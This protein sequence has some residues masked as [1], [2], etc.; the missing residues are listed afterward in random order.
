MNNSSNSIQ[1]FHPQ[2]SLSGYAP[3]F[4]EWNHFR[5]ESHFAICLFSTV[6]SFENHRWTQLQYCSSENV[7]KRLMCYSANICNKSSSS[8]SNKIQVK[9][10]TTNIPQSTEFICRWTGMTLIFGTSSSTCSILFYKIIYSTVIVI[11]NF[12]VFTIICADGNLMSP[13]VMWNLY[14]LLIF[15]HREFFFNNRASRATVR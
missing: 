2:R 15:H 8:S 11:I 6:S 3:T 7:G 12:A 5:H 10:A 9:N 14:K 4:D 1:Y 13:V